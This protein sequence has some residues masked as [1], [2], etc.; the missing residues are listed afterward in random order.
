[1]IEVMPFDPIADEQYCIAEVDLFRDLS[2]REMAALGARAPRRTSDAGQIVYSPAEPVSLLF[3]VK[4]GRVRLYRVG[5]DGRSVT[6]AVLEPG[7]VFGEMDLLGLRMRDTWAQALEPTD[8]CLMSR[9]EVRGLLFTDPRIALRIAESLSRRVDEL[10]QRLTDLS[11][12]NIDQRLASTLLSLARR[13]P[14]API[15]LTHQQLASIVGASRERVTTALGELGR[16]DVVSVRRGKITVKD[17]PA[18]RRFA[19]GVPHTVPGR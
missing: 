15:K 6:T 16:A 2:R 4:R 3:I 13:Q 18:L 9:A 1:M 17:L 5:A 14:D 10:E 8:L 12:K 11:C 19:D 7:A